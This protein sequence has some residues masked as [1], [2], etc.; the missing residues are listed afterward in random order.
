MSSLRFAR[1]ALRARPAAFRVPI[2]RRGYAEA[3]SDKI[4]LSLALPHQTIFRSAGV[5]Q[6]NIPA[7]SGE[8]GVLA[9]HVP[10][11]EQ[12][13]PGLVEIMEEGGASKKFFL[14]GGFAVVQPDSQLSINAVEGYALED[15]S[16]DSVR[17]QITEAQKI[18]GG[19]GSE[20][21][22]AEAK[23]E[24]ERAPLYTMIEDLA[25]DITTPLAHER[26]PL[27]ENDVPG[28]HSIDSPR[29]W[30]VRTTLSE[31]LG[32]ASVSMPQ[33]RS[34]KFGRFSSD[35][36]YNDFLFTFPRLYPDLASE[37]DPFID[38]RGIPLNP[39]NTPI[40]QSGHQSEIGSFEKY[41]RHDPSPIKSDKRALGRLGN[42]ARSDGSQLTS[43]SFGSEATW[44]P[45][46]PPKPSFLS[47]IDN[48][49]QRE[50]TNAQPP[51][52][53]KRPGR[54]DEKALP[55]TPYR[56]LPLRASRDSNQPIEHPATDQGPDCRPAR[57][58]Q[59]W[60]TKKVA[61]PRFFPLQ[62][63]RQELEALSAPLN[64]P[65]MPF[66]A[67]IP[68]IENL[69]LRR[70]AVNSGRYEAGRSQVDGDNSSRTGLNRPRARKESLNDTLWELSRNIFEQLKMN[71]FHYFKPR[72]QGQ[73]PTVRT[74]VT[75]PFV[76]RCETGP[77][78]QCQFSAG[79]VDGTYILQFDLT[80]PLLSVHRTA[81]LAAVI[82]H[83]MTSKIALV[84]AFLVR[85]L[86]KITTLVLLYVFRIDIA[87]EMKRV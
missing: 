76:S 57:P 44:R 59:S 86:I 46:K 65:K 60:E 29:S 1:S 37:K 52:R 16:I 75:I 38:S 19:N 18:A 10:S 62:L 11:I 25:T 27:E 14:S 6:V 32:S 82:R 33:N 35:D 13:K 41:K 24:L 63:T 31:P 70:G 47:C 8:M 22:I 84:A 48:P 9:N 3:V 71:A 5:V 30:H 54:G 7:E 34:H 15:F 67:P 12:L 45:P 49:L 39:H 74:T 85:D 80:L 56:S 79:L 40:S 43:L 51:F 58:K 17:S 72:K 36:A 28:G 20:Q 42:T 61:P 50:A 64:N 23:I 77:E 4:K 69:P 78:E 26:E 2:Q 81:S 53:A 21:D 83:R 73:K 55:E 87:I 68:T 66:P